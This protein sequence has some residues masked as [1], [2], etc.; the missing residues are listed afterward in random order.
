MAELDLA[1]QE[2]VALED[3]THSLA[4]RIAGVD[5]LRAAANTAAPSDLR[6]AS[7]ALLAVLAHSHSTHERGVASALLREAIG[8][9]RWLHQ[10]GGQA[11]EPTNIEVAGQSLIAIMAT[12]D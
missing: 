4:E 7:R 5:R 10:G 2:I 12:R 9:P 6:T 3:R 11:A 8:N 1:A